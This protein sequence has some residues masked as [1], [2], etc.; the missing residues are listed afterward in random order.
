MQFCFKDGW[1]RQSISWV[2]VN[3]LSTVKIF[4]S[5]IV[6]VLLAIW[7]SIS[8]IDNTGFSIFYE[9]FWVSLLL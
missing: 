6:M 7:Q 4:N 9:E 8:L 1:F 5:Y 3:L 2:E